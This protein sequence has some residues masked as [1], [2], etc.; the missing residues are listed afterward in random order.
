[1]P[2]GDFNND[3]RDVVIAGAAT[4]SNHVRVFSGLNLFAHGLEV[5]NPNDDLADFNFIAG[6]LNGMLL[7]SEDLNQDEFA[8]IIAFD[9][10]PSEVRAIS[11]ADLSGL[12]NPF[13]PPSMPLLFVPGV[14]PD[15][16]G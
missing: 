10:V 2:W 5:Q 12:P 11:G 16:S 6:S 8:D 15:E 14:S 4:H 1:M 7:D 13:P 3:D 9:R